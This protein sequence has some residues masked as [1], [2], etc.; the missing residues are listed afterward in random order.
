MLGGV[1]GDGGE[2]LSNQPQATQKRNNRA[3]F[4][5]FFKQF[6]QLQSPPAFFWTVL[7]L[8]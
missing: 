7:P 6:F 2:V 3:L 8:N 5:C 1:W 4:V